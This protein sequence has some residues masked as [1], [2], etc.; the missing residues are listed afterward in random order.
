MS[1]FQNFVDVFT[2]FDP[3]IFRS[4]HDEDFMMVRETELSTLDEHCEIIN[5]LAAAP[6]WDWHLKAELI[7]ENK[8]VM[9]C[10][11]RDGDE[12]VTNVNMIKNAKSWRSI[13]SRVP[14]LQS[15]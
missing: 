9:E 14:I 13:V 2:N 8:Y 4:L 5:E 7:H 1:L 10:R 11:W 6:E 3:D 12:M 15:N